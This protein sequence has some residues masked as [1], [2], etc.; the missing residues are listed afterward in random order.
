MNRIEKR[1]RLEQGRK[2]TDEPARRLHF[3]LLDGLAVDLRAPRRWSW[4]I[5][6]DQVDHAVLT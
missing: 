6:L 4:T 1:K 3:S 2:A 5:L